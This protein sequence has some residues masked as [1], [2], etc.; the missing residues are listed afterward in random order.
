L[1]R[2]I[3]I[4]LPLGRIVED[5]DPRVKGQLINEQGEGQEMPR[6]ISYEMLLAVFENIA[7]GSDPQSDF[8]TCFAK[9]FCGADSFSRAEMM[10]AARSF[11]LKYDLIFKQSMRGILRYEQYG[12][13]REKPGQL[14]AER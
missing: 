13:R 7:N 8:L 10:S 2:R 12:A 1:Q 9:A 11:A 4:A 5:G 6:Y 14:Q 3:R